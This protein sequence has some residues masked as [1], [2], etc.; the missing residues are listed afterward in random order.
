MADDGVRVANS[1]RSSASLLRESIE[2]QGGCR[3]YRALRDSLEGQ[4]SKASVVIQVVAD[5]SCVA[6]KINMPFSSCRAHPVIKRY[7]S[8][9]SLPIQC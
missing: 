9:W 8:N 7:M 5:A 2:I 1:R 6:H 4:H 3:C